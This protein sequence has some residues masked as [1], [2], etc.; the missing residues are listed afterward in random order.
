LTR[1]IAALPQTL[2]NEQEL[3]PNP[4]QERNSPQITNAFNAL[5]LGIQDEK[6]WNGK[7]KVRFS[8]KKTGKKFDLN[9][10]FKNR[11]DVGENTA[12]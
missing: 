7:Y 2:L 1:I 8:S 4:N 3:F 11:G 6:V 9:I 5:P 10:E 12:T